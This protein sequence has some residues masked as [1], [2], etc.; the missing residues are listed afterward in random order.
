VR[1]CQALASTQ[2]VRQSLK[3]FGPSNFKTTKNGDKQAA[4]DKPRP[5]RERLL[6]WVPDVGLET[7]K[8]PD[9]SSMFGKQPNSVTRSQS[10]GAVELGVM[11][12]NDRG[13][14]PLFEDVRV[15]R[16]DLEV[17]VDSRQPG[18]LVEI[19]YVFDWSLPNCFTS[20]GNNIQNTGNTAQERR[21]SPSI[22]GTLAA[23]TTSMQAPADG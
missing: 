4:S 17:G 19:R 14:T 11:R 13:M 12:P 23:D 1:F 10:S 9:D 18:D 6:S 21:S 7:Y 8:I 15:G 3:P 2:T 5:I 20:M 22:L 16:H